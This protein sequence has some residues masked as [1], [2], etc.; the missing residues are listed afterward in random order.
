[1]ERLLIEFPNIMKR[2][3][4]MRSREDPYDNQ[5]LY[6]IASE[7]VKEHKRTAIRECNNFLDGCKNV[8]NAN[9]YYRNVLSLIEKV[10]EKI[11]PDQAE[12]LENKF[13][14]D[15]VPYI[16]DL[17]S[18]KESLS[19]FNINREP[20]LKAIKEN[21]ICNRILKNHD[22]LNKRFDF[23][24]F[25]LENTNKP[26]EDN[27]LYCC[28]MIDTYDMPSYAKLNVALEEISY[29]LQKNAVSYDRSELVQHITEYF[30]HRDQKTST[31]TLNE[32]RKVLQENCC[33][34]DDDLS[35]VS[36]FASPIT[37]SVKEDVEI[38]SQ[39]KNDNL[40]LQARISSD[41]AP[42]I[43]GI[44]TM[45]NNFK[46]SESKTPEDF[47]KL[48]N[49]IN[50]KAS[51]RDMV[52]SVP[53][54]LNWYREYIFDLLGRDI[55]CE[56]I[57]SMVARIMDMDLS[58]SDVQKVLQDF[59]NEYHKICMKRKQLASKTSYDKK[60]SLESQYDTYTEYIAFLQSVIL[61]LESYLNNRPSDSME[62]DNKAYTARM[63]TVDGP[64]TI[65]EAKIFKF[66]NLIMATRE[67][68]KW[69]RN[70]SVHIT[71]AINKYTKKVFEPAIKWFKE[72]GTI[73]NDSTIILN[74]IKS[75]LTQDD[76]FDK[77]IAIYEINETA[78]HNNIGE[79]K[80]AVEEMC[81]GVNN[82][83]A[84]ELL[85]NT[86]YVYYNF[87][88]E[89]YLE[90]HVKDDT[91]INTPVDFH[92]EAMDQFTESDK[93]YLYTA[94]EN[95]CALQNIADITEA[96]AI[97]NLDEISPMFN[98]DNVIDIIEASKYMGGLVSSGELETL[99]ENYKYRNPNDFIGLN[100][101]N[102]AMSKYE[103]SDAVTEA[104][105]I[106]NYNEFMNI[107][108][109]ANTSIMLENVS[110][111]DKNIVKEAILNEKKSSDD[112]DRE[113]PN[114]LADYNHKRFLKNHA[115]DEKIVN[116]NNIN[117]NISH[118]KQIDDKAKKL[119]EEKKAKKE[120]EKNKVNLASKVD[121]KNSD[122]KKKFGKLNLNAIKLAA[123]SFG[124]KIKKLGTK[125]QEMSRDADITVN[126]F[127][128]AMKQAMVS[129]RRESIIRGSVV[130][131]F[132]KGVKIAIGLA[133]I[134][135]IPTYGPLL[136]M[137][138]AIGGFAVSK[139]LTRKERAL[140]LDEIDIELKAL[141]KELSM[142]ENGNDMR[143]YRKLLTYQKKLQREKDRIRMNIKVGND[144]LHGTDDNED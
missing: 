43:T 125:E 21:T 36:Y 37:E 5:Y 58:E 121:D 103:V 33:I 53:R 97:L 56:A 120:A 116:D 29:I 10:N 35:L 63:D 138:T 98:A 99:V 133:G 31:E 81:K 54:M 71:K 76:T 78:T 17:K 87:V 38:Y 122:D 111:E 62:A 2:D 142:A 46:A 126:H 90:I 60:E 100:A 50:T 7:S 82:R 119:R 92:N 114:N 86:S 65:E 131:S 64:I 80:T 69:L 34:T 91:P 8:K 1:M 11:S 137:I 75:G 104:E 67:V 95:A 118:R 107:V 40:Y 59:V 3:M 101:I 129:D 132:S 45:V 32:Y 41:T 15:I 14:K 12:L 70:K 88:N 124:N 141:D 77:V 55:V 66:K 25:I 61:D 105:A 20:I 108:F 39:D 94:L 143:K 13:A 106:R 83:L 57:R 135:A 93:F 18:L 72:D 139:N 74:E 27:I 9:K 128:K 19:R 84:K 136:A 4:A 16:E 127:T 49:D 117:D 140:L 22:K 26:L 42:H 115:K 24:K 52:N 44:E 112:E 89:T 134:A 30:L 85:H 144:Y 123:M 79:L 6:S 68:D 73:L 109:Q 23:S 28:E 47:A 113:R 130:P 48:M 110:D 51:P 102:N 96:A